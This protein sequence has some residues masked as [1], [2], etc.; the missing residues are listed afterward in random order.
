VVGHPRFP[1]PRMLKVKEFA[2]LLGVSADLIE[3]QCRANA[4]PHIRLGRRI[5]IPE[6]AVTTMLGEQGWVRA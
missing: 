3:S 1:N 4:I 6:D 2:E 5:L